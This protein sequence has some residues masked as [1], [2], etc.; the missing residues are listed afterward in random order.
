M[1][2]ALFDAVPVYPNIYGPNHIII[3]PVLI[4]F[5]ILKRMENV[6]FI[7]SHFC[8]PQKKVS[9]TTN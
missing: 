1:L 4:T 8:I 9:P 5:I 3:A 6:F 2:V 7:N